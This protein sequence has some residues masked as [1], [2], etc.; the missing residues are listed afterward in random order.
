MPTKRVTKPRSWLSC[1]VGP[2]RAR[3]VLPNRR[4]VVLA[5]V[6]VHDPV[7]R[8]RLR[9]GGQIV[10]PGPRRGATPGDDLARRPQL[11]EVVLRV[12][13]GLVGLGVDV[14]AEV[15]PP[16]PVDEEDRV[17]ALVVAVRAGEIAF[18]LRRVDV[19]DRPRDVEDV[20]DLIVVLLLKYR[21]RARHAR[22]LE[23]RKELVLEERALVHE[24]V[25]EAKVQPEA[26]TRQP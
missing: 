19:Q 3:Q 13:I 21:R 12:G 10:E 7:V 18:D 23:E 20:V 24:P 14:E 5:L 4:H 16:E 17:A 22:A 15:L 1:A 26:P 9:A 8:P 6:V 2:I 11:A 25:A